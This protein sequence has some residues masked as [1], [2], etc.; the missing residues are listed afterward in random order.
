LGLELRLR[1]RFRKILPRPCH[2]F[3]EV[4]VAEQRRE[5][6]M[7]PQLLLQD[8]LAQRPDREAVRRAQQMDRAA[9]CRRADDTTIE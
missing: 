7:I 1:T 4:D 9:Q 6:A 2:R 8:R 3:V 5:V